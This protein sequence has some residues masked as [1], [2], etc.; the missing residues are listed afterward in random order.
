MLLLTAAET[1]RVY[2]KKDL[3]ILW[4]LG[5]KARVHTDDAPKFKYQDHVVELHA[6]IG[7]L[8]DKCVY[9][10]IGG[11]GFGVPVEPKYLTRVPDDTPLTIQYSD[12]MRAEIAAF[13]SKGIARA[14]WLIE[15]Q[16]YVFE[17]VAA[18]GRGEK[19]NWK[20]PAE[21]I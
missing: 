9:F 17:V 5:I 15:Y 13:R 10:F 6:R 7:Q 20:P 11:D 21:P 16:K 1:G 18:T 14:A 12:K 2:D 19:L 4:G 8:D 3:L